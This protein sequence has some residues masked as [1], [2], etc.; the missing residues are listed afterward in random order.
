MTCQPEFVPSAPSL[1]WA[2]LWSQMRSLPTLLATLAVARPALGQTAAYWCD[3]DVVR[4]LHAP[5]AAHWSDTTTWRHGEVPQTGETVSLSTADDDLAASVVVNESVTVGVVALLGKAFKLK[6]NANA[7]MRLIGGADASLPIRVCELGVPTGLPTAQPSTLP[8]ALPTSLSTSLP[9]AAPTPAPAPTASPA[10]L[11]TAPPSTIRPTHALSPVPTQ[12]PTLAPTPRPSS[13]AITIVPLSLHISAI[14]C[15][16]YG[17][18]EEAAVNEALQD[19]ISGAMSL[20]TAHKCTDVGGDADGRRRQLLS[21]ALVVETDATVRDSAYS[22]SAASKDDIINSAQSTPADSVAT[23]AL[24]DAIIDAI[25]TLD[26]SSPL[27]AAEFSATMPPSPSPT[28]FSSQL[29]QIAEG[30]DNSAIGIM[31]VNLVLIIGFCLYMRKTLGSNDRL[32]FMNLVA[33]VSGWIDMVS[34]FLFGVEVGQTE[35]KEGSR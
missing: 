12:V 31:V 13:A 35:R 20:F 19:A 29:P 10:P 16:D 25:A 7:P 21:D 14:S 5:T 11:S 3:A 18:D 8:S 4:A 1:L 6:L 26:P 23:D 15:E 17:S 27:R 2:P 24:G 9:T 32:T 28:S 34:D 22:G 30:W 33:I